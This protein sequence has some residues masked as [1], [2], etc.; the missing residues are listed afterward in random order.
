MAKIRDTAQTMNRV[1]KSLKKAG[2]GDLRK[3][4]HKEMRE[5]AKPI[6]PKVRKSAQS[7]FPT[8]GGL[9]RHMARGTRYRSVVLTGRNPGVSIRANKTDPR[10][11]TEGRI[12]HPIPR[13]GSVRVQSTNVK[14]RKVKTTMQGGEFLTDEKG[15]RLG[16]VQYFPEA[17]GYF[18]EPIEESADEM[19]AAMTKR[20]EWWA[21]RL[22]KG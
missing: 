8:E 5:A 22:L 13:K 9:S 18:S 10:T 14:T 7:R 11:D 15:R 2:A 6:L 3:Q 20:L 17:V 1:S 12:W 16:A 21:S 19:I 4:F